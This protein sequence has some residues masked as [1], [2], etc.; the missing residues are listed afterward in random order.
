MR[1]KEQKG[2]RKRLVLQELVFGQPEK[3]ELKQ[4]TE[5]HQVGM[6][7]RQAPE[8]NNDKMNFKFE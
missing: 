8:M 3:K 5:I 2:K 6:Q 4:S 7:E 1:S